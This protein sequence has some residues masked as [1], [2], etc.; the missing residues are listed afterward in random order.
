MWPAAY[1]QL[2]SDDI[3]HRIHLRVLR[4]IQREA[5]KRDVVRKGLN[6][7]S[8]KLLERVGSNRL[9]HRVLLP[10]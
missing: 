1:W 10:D 5:E 4:H 7:S 3:I 6:P 2:W 8:P 9:S